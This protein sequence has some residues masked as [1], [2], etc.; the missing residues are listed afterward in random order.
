[1]PRG[2]FVNNHRAAWVPLQSSRRDHAGDGPFNSLGDYVC[3]AF[4]R[5]EQQA[6]ARF[7]DSADSH[8]N[9][10]AWNI[11]FAAEE[12]G[13]LLNRSGREGFDARARAQ[14]RKRFVKAD[15]PSLADA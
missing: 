12:R 10:P 8:S 3:L 9:G 1:V 4:T 14:R 13:V 6:P 5:R 15:V 7:Q 11:L 2:S